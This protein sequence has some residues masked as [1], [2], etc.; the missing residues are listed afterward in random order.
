MITF[1][2]VTVKS[3]RY[4]AAVALPL[5]TMPELEAFS[6]KWHLLGIYPDQEQAQQA[7]AAFIASGQAY[8]CHAVAEQG[9]SLFEHLAGSLAVPC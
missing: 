3:P 4:L 5:N 1:D 2:Q 9:S 6:S 7:V 8:D